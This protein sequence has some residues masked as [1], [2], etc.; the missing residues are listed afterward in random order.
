MDNKAQHLGPADA[1]AARVAAVRSAVSLRAST[2]GHAYA[3]GAGGEAGAAVGSAAA[4]A[5]RV[6]ITIRGLAL[7]PLPS[8]APLPDSAASAV[9]GRSLEG[10]SGGTAALA[11]RGDAMISFFPKN[12]P[13]AAGMQRILA[14]ASGE[15]PRSGDESG[16]A[17]G[18]A[19]AQVNAKAAALRSLALQSGSRLRESAQTG[20]RP[21]CDAM[22]A[23]VT[24]A[25]VQE[26]GCSAL[27]ALAVR[28]LEAKEAKGSHAVRS[29]KLGEV[30]AMDAPL[31]VEATRACV[32]AMRA[33]PDAPGVQEA[34]L[35]ALRALALVSGASVAAEGVENDGVEPLVALLSAQKGAAKSLEQVCKAMLAITSVDQEARRKAV[36]AGGIQAL[37]LQLGSHADAP[38]LAAAALAALNSLI[39]GDNPATGA[40]A[41]GIALRCGAP[42]AT[43]GALAAFLT[44]GGARMA[45]PTHRG[46]SDASANLC[47]VEAA[48]TCMQ[49]LSATQV[50]LTLEEARMAGLNQHAEALANPVDGRV[51]CVRGDAVRMLVAALRR[52]GGESAA[53][54]ESGVNAL[55]QLTAI[56]SAKSAA[57]LGGALEAVV[58]SMLAHPRSVGVQAA[59]CGALKS[60]AVLDDVR[61]RDAAEAAVEALC[62]SLS[63]HARAD[64]KLAEEACGALCNLTV[65][66]SEN[67]LALSDAG[68][69]AVIAAAMAA[70]PGVADLQEAG[71]AALWA[72]AA[73]GAACGAR[74]AREGGIEAVVRA[75]TLFPAQ[76]TVQVVA[77]AALKNLAGGCPENEVHV[78]AAGGIET[79]LE[80]LRSHGSSAALQ[81]VGL[82]ALSAITASHAAIRRWAFQAGALEVATAAVNTRFPNNEGVKRAAKGALAKL[83]PLKTGAN[84]LCGF[85]D[86]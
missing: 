6:P 24:N 1:V 37:V 34:A 43:A 60:L 30:A 5:A 77:L 50:T 66:C 64:A 26:S 25:A 15:G 2:S 7:P 68:G 42:K 18:A 58:A 47:G 76:Q 23:H 20:V 4:P 63:T 36:A 32:T 81:E 38:S 39:T 28:C 85:V 65:G 12:S 73:G 14:H 21:V 75:M 86:I 74:A 79:V 82:D 44:G 59:C 41:I 53:C 67:A 22:T 57:A 48:C 17:E 8:S 70:H 61:L 13:E 49:L 54:A 9:A 83:N 46:S 69:A 78:A 10:P 52:Y 27:R 51:E 62:A 31:A 84:R 40:E 45:P 33:H 29:A 11:L 19:L 71:C 56:S 55:R 16:A 35:L 80:A 72:L 3:E